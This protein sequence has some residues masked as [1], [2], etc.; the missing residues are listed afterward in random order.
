MKTVGTIKV[1]ARR[2]AGQIKKLTS[3]CEESQREKAKISEEE[4]M[5]GKKAI[6]NFPELKEDVV[7]LMVMAP[8]LFLLPPH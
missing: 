6:K 3:V 1:M 8:K 7:D 5:F 4:E 2:D